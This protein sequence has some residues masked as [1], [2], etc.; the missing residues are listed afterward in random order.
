MFSVVI[1]YL[2][3]L[4]SGF[5]A[6]G[7]H[8]FYLGKFGTGIIWLFSGGLFGFGC[9]WD[10]FTLPM[11][12]RQANL[13]ARYRR[14]LAD[15]YHRSEAPRRVESRSDFKEGFRRDIQRDNIEQVILKTAKRN[16][17]IA[18][19]SEV[20]LNSGLSLEEVKKQFEKLASGGYVEM[21][22]TKAGGIVYL[23]KD[24]VTDESSLDLED[25]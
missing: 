12:V 22:V 19:P 8:R 4:I 5:G 11:Q 2:L 6:L 10:F 15:D 18:T 13:E 25:F 14:V 17:G 20:A 7:F 24:F 16:N 1:A 23:I 3:W 21:R 9:I